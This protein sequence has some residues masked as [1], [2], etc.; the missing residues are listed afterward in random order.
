[1]SDLLFE[2]RPVTVES[3]H[4]RIGRGAWARLF[5]SGVIGDESASVAERGR[6]HARDGDVHSVRVAEGELS[7]VVADCT[8]TLRADP[9][10]PRVWST[11]ARSARRNGRLVDGIEGRE[12]SVHLEH[13][14]RFE[15]DE[16]LVPDRSSLLRSCTCDSDRVCEHVV[17]V[18]YVVADQID[19]DPVLLLRWRG[20]ADVA[21]EEEEPAQPGLLETVVADDDPWQAG[22]LPAPRPARPLPVG[23]ILKSL[24]PSGIRATAGELEDALQRAYASF[25]KK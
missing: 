6:A 23:A 10:P 4:D 7:G 24:G 17:A 9:I 5:A 21:E 14:M 1:V 2:G 12:Q 11:V 20:I 19:R 3:E 18:A 16:P 8:V 13:V 22:P 25:A 15:W